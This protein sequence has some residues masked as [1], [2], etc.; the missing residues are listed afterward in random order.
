VDLNPA[1]VAWCKGPLAFLTN[2]ASTDR[3]V[4]IIVGDVARVIADAPTASYDAVVLDL[5]EGPH[6]ANNRASD[7]LYGRDG[8]ER[9]AEA[10]TPNG[11]F[12]IWS[13]EPDKA[14]ERRLGE[15]FQV[16]RHRGSRGGRSHLVYVATRQNRRRGP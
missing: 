14:F 8:L 12:A 9:T 3:R 6:G 4:K 2:A 1:V 15:R 13:E 5:Y 10:L 7:P 16:T 11:V